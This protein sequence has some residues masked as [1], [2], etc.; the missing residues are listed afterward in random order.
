MTGKELF[1]EIKAFYAKRK[2]IINLVVLAV[3]LAL[4]QLVN[5]NYIMGIICRMLLYS[6][7]AGSLNAINGYSGQ[8]NIGHAGFF[9]IGAY[10][11]AIL[12]TRFGVSFWI[13]LVVSG[14]SASLVGFLI[15]LPT[16][17][18]RG[19][20]LAIVT[21][22]FSEI[23]RILALNWSSVTGG[24]MGIKDIPS[25]VFMGKVISRASDYYYIFLLVAVVFLVITGRVLKSRVGRAWISIREDETAAKSL[26]VESR[27][28]KSINF[29]YGSFWAGVAGATFAPYYRFISSDMFTLDEGFNI[30]SMVIIGGQGTLVGPLAG[31]LIVT[32][33]TEVFRFAAQYRMVIYAILIIAMMWWRPQGLVGAYDSV[34]AVKKKNQKPLKMES[35]KVGERS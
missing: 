15:S 4:P 12:A 28:Y 13:L 30:L 33:I 16:M 9:C 2:L 5:S 10:T 27:F 24:P 1:K 11:E 18:L 17:R 14:I 8:F 34:F 25:P 32:L 29:M 21:L 26:G 3:L 22:G 35:A 6:V 19:I 20:Y 23:I 31:A 7:L